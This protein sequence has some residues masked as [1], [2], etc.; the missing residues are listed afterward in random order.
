MNNYGQMYVRYRRHG[1][2]LVGERARHDEAGVAS[3][4]TEIHQTAL[5]K[6]NDSRIGVWEDPA[7]S[8]GLNG[9]SLDT[10]VGLQTMHVNLIV[11]VANVANYHIVFHLPHMVYHQYVLV[12]CGGHKDV[13]FR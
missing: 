6:N 11:K 1:K 3:S 7:I 13:S 2:N 9:D 12:S 4:T 8:L 10:R 5:S